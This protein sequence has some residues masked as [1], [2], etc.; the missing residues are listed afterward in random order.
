MDTRA[1]AYLNKVPDHQ[2]YPASRCALTEGVCMFMRT[3]SSAVESMNRANASVRERTAVDPINAC[4]L[5]LKLEG[6]RFGKHRDLAHKHSEILTPHGMKLMTKAFKDVNP[7]EFEI[8][9]NPQGDRLSC[10]VNRIISPNIY[11]CW[12][13]AIEQEGSLFGDC[14]CGVPRVDGI[15][16]E[17]M[18]AVCKSKK[19]DGLNENNIMPLTYHT[20]LWRKQYPSGVSVTCVTNIDDLRRASNPSNKFMLCPAIS[21]P[22][23]A[24]RPK[25]MKR[26]KSS[27][28]L[29]MEKLVETK[30]A[31]KIGPHDGSKFAPEARGDGKKKVDVVMTKEVDAK[32]RK[33][34]GG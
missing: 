15:P 5:L 2:Q 6:E 16:C 19:I 9:I 23:K 21:A 31:A 7:R 22:R 12:F 18:V 30:K 24:G 20:S 34:V 4:I 33:H 17:H 32:K 3:A 13:H 28:E 14:T 25:V 26:I 10:R 8:Y 27:Q 1:V 29:A 11:T